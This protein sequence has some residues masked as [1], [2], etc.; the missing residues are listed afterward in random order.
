MVVAQIHHRRKEN[1]DLVQKNLRS[2]K[3]PKCSWSRGCTI[4]WCLKSVICTSIDNGELRREPSSWGY[5]AAI[6]ALGD[7]RLEQ[8]LSQYPGRQQPGGLWCI[9]QN[10]NETGAEK[11]VPKGIR[12]G[13]VKRRPTCFTFESGCSWRQPGSLSRQGEFTQGQSP[14]NLS[15][16]TM[17]GGSDPC[18][19]TGSLGRFQR[20]RSHLT[21]EIRYCQ[22]LGAGQSTHSK[23]YTTQW[24]PWGLIR[25]KPNLL[26]L[27]SQNSE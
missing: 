5:L 10:V 22:A 17:G 27:P 18:P 7:R 24:R 8:I 2:K 6:E 12:V 3:L 19:T 14:W 20:N 13:R 25:P 1:T 26:E 11:T 21:C 15:W 9:W 16:P 4:Q 23:A